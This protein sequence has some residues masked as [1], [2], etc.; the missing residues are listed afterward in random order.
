MLFRSPNINSIEKIFAFIWEHG[1]A[2]EHVAD[3]NDLLIELNIK[4]NDLENPAIKQ[5]LLD[6]TNQAIARQVFGV[7]TT[8]LTT[9][10]LTEQRFWGFDSTPMV[11]SAL[12]DDAFWVSPAFLDASK[13]PQGKSRPWP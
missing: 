6:N 7:P 3:F 1:H 4:Q 13:L 5:A 9:E 12:N 11:L 8:V 2:V 10:T